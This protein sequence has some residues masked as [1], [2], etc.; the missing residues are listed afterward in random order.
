M[1][2][3]EKHHSP[4]SSLAV[5]RATNQYRAESDVFGA[6]LDEETDQASDL[7]AGAG[8]L[9]E[10]Y[11]EWCERNWEWKKSQKQFGL[12]L[13]ERGLEREKHP[14]TR[15]WT[16]LGIGLK[17]QGSETV[18]N[19][20]H[21]FFSCPP[22]EGKILQTVSDRFGT[23]GNHARQGVAGDAGAKALGHN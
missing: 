6:F 10:R 18:R 15:R 20:A 17:N 9:Y 3:S 19:G 11:K 14:T 4:V 22:H 5:T 1:L 13:Q 7:S 21:G 16:Y 23:E 12:Y 2:P 8:E